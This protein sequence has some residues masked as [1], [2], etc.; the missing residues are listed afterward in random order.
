MM[1]SPI[2]PPTTETT[3]SPKIPDPNPDPKPKP[4]LS[5]VLT[6]SSNGEA[7]DSTTPTPN[8]SKKSV[9]WSVDL[10]EE[11]TLPPLDKTNA[12]DNGDYNNRYVIR[13]S[14][15]NSSSQ[16]FNINNSMVNIKDTFGRW[17][18]KVGE[19]TKKAEDLAGNTWQ[20]L[21]TAPS[22]TDGALGRIAQGTKVL[23]E[24]G[25]EKIFR[26]TFETVPEE[27]LKNSYACYLSTS[28]GPVLG[29]L[30]V[31][32]AKLAFCSDNP[33]SYKNVDKTEWSYYKV[34]PVLMCLSSCF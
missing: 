8:R 7:T 24:G 26:Q 9:R 5:P 10:V 1:E 3:N 19:A 21:K 30:Y 31:S 25:Y 13:S 33:L 27:L 20:H 12:D 23:A 29:V 15:S 18:K 34:C 14:E 4:D 32:T 28:A 2:A 22:L 17:R 16:S 11:R 6:E